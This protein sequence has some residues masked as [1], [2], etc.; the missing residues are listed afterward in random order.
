[1]KILRNIKFNIYHINK[2]NFHKK[3]YQIYRSIKSDVLMH[4]MF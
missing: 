3:K 4:K 1:M 2:I